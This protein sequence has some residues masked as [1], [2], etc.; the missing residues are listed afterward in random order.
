MNE[1]LERAIRRLEDLTYCPLAFM[2]K[3]EDGIL[4][5]PTPESMLPMIPIPHC[6]VEDRYCDGYAKDCRIRMEY[7]HRVIRGR[8]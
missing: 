7:V 8:C 5:Y 6:L 1:S 2:S 4:V 3:F